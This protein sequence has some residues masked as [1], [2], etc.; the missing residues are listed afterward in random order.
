MC[1]IQNGY[2]KKMSNKCIK[3]KVEFIYHHRLRR[4]DN[5]GRG[6]VWC[7][8]SS[9]LYTLFDWYFGVHI[10]V[11]NMTLVWKG[12]SHLCRCQKFT[13]KVKE[14]SI[15]FETSNQWLPKRQN[16]IQ[17]ARWIRIKWSQLV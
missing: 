7:M 17:K 16:N 12:L 5:G 3:W 14:K 6:H 11:H 15:N 8:C 2:K 9:L 4:F 10:F 1:L 13:F